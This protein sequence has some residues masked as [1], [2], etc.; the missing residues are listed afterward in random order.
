[1]VFTS[2]ELL[3]P[4]VRDNLTRIF[5]APVYDI[6]GTPET[7]EIAWQ[8]P[9]GG[10]HLNADV[11][12]LEAVDDSG[13][14]L[15]PNREGELVATLL[16][17]RAMPLLRY[18][19]GDRGFLRLGRCS[20]GSPLPLVGLVTGRSADI[21]ILRDG[22]RISPSALNCAIERVP[23][24][25]RYQVNQLDQ[26][27]IRIRAILDGTVDRSVVTAQVRSALR[28]DV[29]P[30]LDAEVEFVDHLPTGPQAKLRVVERS[31][32]PARPAPR[33]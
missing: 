29:A 19:T 6:Y 20:C 33:A 23:G 22:H 14:S 31:R 1:M 12:H 21:L 25:L 26:A 30:Y 27:K 2:G 16:I 3:Q 5:G 8:C 32:D 9:D 18:R 4:V 28:Y 10:M 13:R 7:K 15:P 11:V 24:V 17:N